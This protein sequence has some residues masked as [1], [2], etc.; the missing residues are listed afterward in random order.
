MGKGVR[1]EEVGMLD[2]AKNKKGRHIFNRAIIGMKRAHEGSE[3]GSGRDLLPCSS[4]RSSVC[5]M[6]KIIAASTF[7]FG[8]SPAD[9]VVADILLSLN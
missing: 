9:D 2:F 8:G 7:R 3:T 4:G 6:E 5:H 1:S